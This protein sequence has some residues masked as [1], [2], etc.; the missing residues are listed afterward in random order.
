[1]VKYYWQMWLPS[2]LC[3][4][5]KLNL[6]LPHSKTSTVTDRLYG[7]YDNLLIT[8]GDGETNFYGTT[9]T[10]QMLNER[11]PGGWFGGQLGQGRGFWGGYAD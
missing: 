2:T 4:L 8:S 11:F 1:M 7:K 10:I 9:E 3:Y 6:D 5:R